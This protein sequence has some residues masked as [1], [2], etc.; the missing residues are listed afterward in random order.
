MAQVYFHCSSAH[1]VMLDRRGTDVEDLRD[2]RSYA[3]RFVRSLVDSPS[4]ED[5]RNWVLD[6]RDEEDG[7][8]LVIPFASLLGRSH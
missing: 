6:I 8:L 1:G 3:V 2:V 4:S 7:E 5:W